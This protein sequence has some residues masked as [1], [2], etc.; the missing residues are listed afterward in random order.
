MTPEQRKLYEMRKWQ[1][2][3]QHLT[4][5]IELDAPKCIKA[6]A[7]FTIIVPRMIRMMNIAK[8]SA[9]IFSDM[10]TAGLGFKS[11]MCCV[12]HAV[13]LY[14]D[15]TEDACPKCLAESDQWAEHFEPTKEEKL[16]DAIFNSDPSQEDEDEEEESDDA[17]PL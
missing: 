6:H 9:Q 1:W 8:E 3:V 17:K 2:A 4:R 7:L 15:S 16:L 10:V 13:P 11:G 14:P 12:C 5:L